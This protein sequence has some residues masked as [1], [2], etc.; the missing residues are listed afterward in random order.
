MAITKS[1]TFEV[2]SPLSGLLGIMHFLLTPAG[3]L[4]SKADTSKVISDGF[5]QMVNGLS[6]V[7][8]GTE[9]KLNE[10]I[11]TV[12]DGGKSVLSDSEVD[13]ILQLESLVEVLRPLLATEDSLPND[14]KL[15]VA[16]VIERGEI[17]KS[18]ELQLRSYSGEVVHVQF[19]PDKLC[20]E[21]NEKH[22][23][24]ASV[25]NEDE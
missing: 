1:D 15:A 25:W 12:L 13:A 8:K 21:A 22:N 14:L 16:R 20:R 4:N 23:L 10:M 3:V 6:V 9:V 24:D 17:L 2:S 19:D 5:I 11:N 7:L 18:L